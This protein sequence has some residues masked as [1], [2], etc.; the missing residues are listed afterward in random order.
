MR[1]DEDLWGDAVELTKLAAEVPASVLKA[2]HD[3]PAIEGTVLKAGGAYRAPIYDGDEIVGFFT[4]R[5]EGEHWRLGPIYV[6]PESRG[7]GLAAAAVR[8]FMQGRV[9]RAE[10][11][12]DNTSSQRLFEAAGFVPMGDGSWVKEASAK[13]HLA[14]R[15]EQRAPQADPALVPAIEGYAADQ[16]LDLGS[17]YHAALPGGA[18]LVLSP[19]GKGDRRKHVAKTVLAPEMKPPGRMLRGAP[20]KVPEGSMAVWAKDHG[21]SS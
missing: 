13:G 9:G 17:T 10:I 18:Y 1:T 16:D 15:L 20:M 12:A 2:A 4:P 19:V 8:S 7:R 3:D 6:Q 21:T 5:Q 14:T 11:D